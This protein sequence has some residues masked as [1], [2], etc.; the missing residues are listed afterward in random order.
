MGLH[1]SGRGRSRANGQGT[2][3]H[4]HVDHHSVAIASLV[5][6]VQGLER[7][8]CFCRVGFGT[9]LCTGRLPRS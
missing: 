8:Q 3:H 9:E 5:G 6:T 4:G 1:L 2:T 7:M